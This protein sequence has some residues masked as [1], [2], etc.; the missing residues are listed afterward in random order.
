MDISSLDPQPLVGLARTWWLICIP[1]GLLT[2]SF[3]FPR[4]AIIMFISSCFVT[5]TIL[6]LDGYLFA[7][8]ITIGCTIGCLIFP[9]SLSESNKEMIFKDYPWIIMLKKRLINDR[10]G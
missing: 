10:S 6:Q 2:L 8:L 1:G 9:Y 7:D 5:Y 3:L 4:F